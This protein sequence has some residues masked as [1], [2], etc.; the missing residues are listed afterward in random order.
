MGAAVCGM[1]SYTFY[2]S[3]YV[4]LFLLP[5]GLG[6]PLLYR[7]T[8]RKERLFRLN[9]QFK[10]GILIL[11]ANLSAGYSLENALAISGQELDMLYGKD[12]MINHEFSGMARQLRMNRTVEQVFFDFAD[13]SGLEDVKNFAQ[14]LKAAKRSGGDLV[15]IINHTAGVIRDKAQVKEE[16]VNMTAAKKLE[17]KIMNVIP[18]FLILYI[19]QAS[20]GFFGMMY[21]TGMGRVLM[22]ICL[23]VYGFALW[24]SKRI[25]DIPI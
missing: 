11:A 23:G 13:R 7:R 25:L 18:F 19:D 16:I 9:Q 5:L 21:E 6:Y 3:M 24:L 1:V 17:Q 15:A 20:P 12:G 14:V 4:F 22:T 2:R 8:L 10:E